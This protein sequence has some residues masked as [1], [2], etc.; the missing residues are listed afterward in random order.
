MRAA[1]LAG[2]SGSPALDDPRGGQGQQRGGATDHAGFA[3]RDLRIELPRYQELAVPADDPVR[4]ANVLGFGVEQVILDRLERQAAP[5]ELP[6]VDQLAAGQQDA[7]AKGAAALVDVAIGERDGVAL[8]PS[9]HAKA[10]A[11]EDENG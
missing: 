5:L 2:S 4:V 7:L 1:R 6:V 11:A 8:G 10:D 9:V 3:S